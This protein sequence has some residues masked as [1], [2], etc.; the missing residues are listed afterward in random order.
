M[1]SSAA[2]SS[3]AEE[4]VCTSSTCPSRSGTARILTTSAG[5]IRAS[6]HTLMRFGRS[7]GTSAWRSAA[8]THADLETLVTGVPP[9]YELA[10]AADLV[11]ELLGGRLRNAPST[12]EIADGR[13]RQ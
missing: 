3:S 7:P 10:A 11:M 2:S 1:S 6:S 13:W 12:D 9:E 4:R 8:S 5:R